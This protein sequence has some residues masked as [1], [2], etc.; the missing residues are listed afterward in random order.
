MEGSSVVLGFFLSTIYVVPWIVALVFV[1]RMIR[2]DGGRPE[3][4]LLIGACLMLVSSVVGSAWARLNPLLVLRMTEAG[5]DY[6]IIGLMFSAINFVRAFISLAG[7][8]LLV[9]AFWQRFEVRT[10]TQLKG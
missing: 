4:F 2:N 1:V 5:I 8:I 7:I 6:K 9:Y 3:R 10:T